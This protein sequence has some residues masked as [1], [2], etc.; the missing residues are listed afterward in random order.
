MELFC[1]VY[2]TLVLQLFVKYLATALCKVSRCD[3]IQKVISKREA[4]REFARKRVISVTLPP[5][6]HAS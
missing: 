2:F 4:I 1:E 6:K 5:S 3:S